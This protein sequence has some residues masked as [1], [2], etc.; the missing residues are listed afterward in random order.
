MKFGQSIIHIDYLFHLYALFDLYVATPPKTYTYLNSDGTTKKVSV[1]FQTLSF[2]FFTELYDLFYIENGV[3]VVPSIIIDLITPIGLAYWYIDDGTQ[4]GKGFLLHTDNF[5]KEHVKLLC[6]ALNL[7]FGLHTNPRL[8]LLD[9]YAIYIP[10]KDR[11]LFLKLITPF[12]HSSMAY[13][14]RLPSMDTIDS[15]N[16]IPPFPFSERYLDNLYTYFSRPASPLGLDYIIKTNT[17]LWV[18][19]LF[20]I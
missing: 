9:Q 15:N 4:A 2:P 3:K 6:S 13:K 11:E 14:L 20:Y 19:V 10:V 1:L 7:K 8:R 12:I 18:F 5:S 16:I 17:S